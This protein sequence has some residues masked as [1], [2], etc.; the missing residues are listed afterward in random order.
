MTSGRTSG[1]I[2]GAASGALSGSAFGPMGTGI[3]AVLGGLFG[4]YSGA[5]TDASQ[6]NQAAWARYNSMLEYN[7]ALY[8]INSRSELTELNVQ[9]IF[10]NTAIETSAIAANAQFNTKVIGMT[11]LYNHS[12]Q[13]EELRRLWKSFDLD[14]LQL[15]NFRARERGSIVAD[16]AAS[17][18]VLA[19]GS[20]EDV[21]VSQMTQEAL[22]KTVI[23]HNADV[24]AADINNAMARGLW[25][26][27]M[28][29]HQNEW[30][31]E[32]AIHQAMARG[33]VAAASQL[34]G[35]AIQTNADLYT[36]KQ[37]RQANNYN[38]QQSDYAYKARNSQSLATGLFNTA[39]A[40]ISSY[41]G[42]KRFGSSKAG[43]SLATGG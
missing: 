17:G 2:S 18:T 27:E 30:E 1:A 39:G 4:G 14:V 31:G 3:G 19:E 32:V 35:N 34:V 7:T 15:E 10:A 5:Q 21:V 9:S 26:G 23:Q 38:I 20:N 22:D 13:K 43:T 29:I 25:E 11:T 8:N 24:A 12:L 33:S 40:G 36:A 16:Q 37:A 28:A 42:R 41:Y 6:E